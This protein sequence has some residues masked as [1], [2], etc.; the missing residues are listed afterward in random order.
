MGYVWH[1]RHWLDVDVA[2]KILGAEAPLS[3]LAVMKFHKEVQAHAS[4]LHPHIVPLYDYGVLKH[5]PKEHTRQDNVLFVSMPMAQFGDLTTLGQLNH[6]NQVWQL[7]QQ[8][9]NALAFAHARGI[10]HRDI[11]PK[12]ILVFDGAHHPNFKLAD[13]GIAHVADLV[14]KEHTKDLSIPIGTPNYMSPEQIQ[15]NWYQYGPWTDLY[16][17]G[18]MIYKAIC[19]RPPFLAT[20]RE[21]LY[22]QHLNAERPALE[23]LFDVPKSVEAWLERLMAIQPQDRFVC[24]AHALAMLPDPFVHESLWMSRDANDVVQASFYIPMTFERA[25][26]TPS[27]ALPV[28]PH[29][30]E[31]VTDLKVADLFNVGGF[32]HW[33][34]HRIPPWQ[35]ESPL[36]EVAPGMGLSLFK[37][38]EIPL[39][40]RLDARDR[41]WSA[42]QCVVDD[43]QLHVVH[44]KGEVGVGKS[45]LVQWVAR[46]V[47]ELG[48]AQVLTCSARYG[49]SGHIISDMFDAFFQSWRLAGESLHQHLQA[50]IPPARVVD[51]PY[52]S[53]VE[54]LVKMMRPAEHRLN[55]QQV[56]AMLTR[57][58]RRLTQSRPLVMVVDDAHDAPEVMQW[59]EHLQGQPDLPVLVLCATETQP[60]LLQ[61][62][63]CVDLLPL[64][65]QESH[66]MLSSVLPVHIS[67][68]EHIHAHAEGNPLFAIQLLNHHIER[69]A[70]SWQVQSFVLNAQKQTVPP[71]IQALWLERLTRLLTL[72]D[73]AQHD[74]ISQSLELA[75]TL[76]GPFELETWMMACAR[77]QV[78]M[79]DGLIEQLLAQAMMTQSENGLR[80]C[81][82]LLRRC[83]MHVATLNHRQHHNHRVVA[84][85]LASCLV[86][87]DWQGAIQVARH[88]I[89]ALQ[90]ENALPLLDGVVTS[91]IQQGA[92]QR[93]QSIVA[94]YH[95][96]V[97]QCHLPPEHYHAIACDIAT[98]VQRINSG[99]PAL[100]IEALMPLYQ[101]ALKRQHNGLAT[102]AAYLIA[103]AYLRQGLVEK[104]SHWDARTV[105]LGTATGMYHLA[106]R[107]FRSVQSFTASNDEAIAVLDKA[108]AQVDA[109]HYI[110][111]LHIKAYILLELQRFQGASGCLRELLTLTR[112]SNDL[113]R[114]MTVVIAQ[115]DL[116]RLQQ[117]VEMAWR[118]YQEALRLAI[119]LEHDLF[120]NIIYY[121]LALT[122]LSAQQWDIARHYVLRAES[123]IDPSIA[124]SDEIVGQ[125]IYMVLCAVDGQWDALR[126]RLE[127]YLP[128]WPDELPSS[129]DYTIPLE[130][131]AQKALKHRPRLALSIFVLVRQ[132]WSRLGQ[133]NHVKRLDAIIEDVG[134]DGSN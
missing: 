85:V 101:Q 116:A 33:N 58:V 122:A 48:V 111:I 66:H 35:V 119:Q 8:L 134:D 57:M 39:C 71:D 100:A 3:R 1:A 52:L 49:T 54:T 16:A 62:D 17:L 24:A 120:I 127:P 97:A 104:A 103:T 43:R 2:V 82:G 117:D 78:Q 30:N 79:P 126:A 12:N 22:E 87:S 31:Q 56:Q 105:K 93:N 44:I 28:L 19:G 90:P 89:N 10:I 20:T 75:A 51:Y 107:A 15:G 95:Q 114:Q 123:H 121:N 38:R 110:N 102:Q 63:C 115:G 36:P 73:I 70:L 68:S 77:A 67:L 21:A 112:Q 7:S 46:R 13:F 109:Q 81:H 59:V 34:A 125:V 84:E 88:W 29:A 99:Q 53:D 41:I 131:A 69:D 124:K 80:L 74:A 96:A 130:I 133:F 47:H 27:E 118:Y 108:L 91:L 50:F 94:L 32:E 132:L 4:L 64:S 23:A 26:C 72:F 129:T 76:G 98:Q 5:P 106:T 14:A 42:L 65:V 86:S 92:L 60:L 11:K 113:Y 37:L 40:G 18:C 128:D 9:L 55:T 25:V 61:V 45:E 6:W 83:L